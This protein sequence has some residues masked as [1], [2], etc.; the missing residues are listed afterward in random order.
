[1]SHINEHLKSHAGY[2]HILSE[3]FWLAPNCFTPD[4]GEVGTKYLVS[5]DNVRVSDGAI[6]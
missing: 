4:I 1:M 3:L 2:R 6:F 5:V